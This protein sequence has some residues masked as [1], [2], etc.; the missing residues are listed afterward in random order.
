MTRAEGDAS[1]TATLETPA[2]AITIRGAI[3]AKWRALRD[4]TTP[5][6]DDV[7][8]HLGLPLAPES[9]LPV[10]C[11]GG[12][13]QLFDRGMIV[14][15]GDGGAFVVYGA[16]YDHYLAAGGPQGS[17]G[18]PRRTRRRPVWEVASPTF[19]TRTSTGAP[20]SARGR[21]TAPDAAA[22]RLAGIRSRPLWVS[23]GPRSSGGSCGASCDVVGGPQSHGHQ[24]QT[25]VHRARGRQRTRI[26][27]VEVVES[28]HPGAGSR[29]PTCAGRCPCAPSRRRASPCSV[30][31]ALSTTLT[32]PAGI[33][34][35][36]V[37]RDGRGSPCGVAARVTRGSPRHPT[38]VSPR[39]PVDGSSA[40]QKQTRLRA[41]SA[42][43]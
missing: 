1:E 8:S 43:T 7:Q 24:R 15:R 31:G 11:G 14:A 13:V 37:A 2:G 40:M 36:R 17:V 39:L 16:I 38:K 18:A 41:T 21:S 20:T 10:R 32:R 42:R 4:E 3:H 28:V 26:D 25:R 30:P 27:D 12:T 6:G 33:S 5:D 9:T 22:T 34:D 23:A 29:S 35:A 19:S